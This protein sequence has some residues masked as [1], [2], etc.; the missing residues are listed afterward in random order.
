M[1]RLMATSKLTSPIVSL[2]L[3]P[4]PRE[5]IDQSIMIGAMDPTRC[6]TSSTQT[7]ELGD[8]KSDGKWIVGVCYYGQISVLTDGLVI[9]FSMFTK[10]F[11]FLCSDRKANV[12]GK[13][14]PRLVVSG[15]CALSSDSV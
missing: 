3:Q 7:A 1:Y 14:V 11:R 9:E 5:D 15:I 2:D 4:R 8:P 6:N 12:N 10:T 13:Q